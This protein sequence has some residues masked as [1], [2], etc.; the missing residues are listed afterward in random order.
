MGITSINSNYNSKVIPKS[1]T[2]GSSFVL[3]QDEDQI[4][5][6]ESSSECC[7]GIVDIVNSTKIAATLPCSK[8]G[9][10]Y[11]IFLNAMIVTV[12]RF[13]GIVVKNGG[14]S[15][16]YYFQE[17]TTDQKSVFLRCLECSLA[18]TEI[19]Q[20]INAKLQEEKIPPL[21][22]R[23]S[24]DYGKV[25][26]AKSCNSSYHDIFGTPVNICSKINCRALPN[27]VVVGSDLYHAAKNSPGYRFHEVQGY[28]VGFKFQYPVYRATRDDQQ[29][30]TVIDTAIKR[31]L[32]EMGTPVLDVITT[33][34]FTE[35]GC[36]L[37]DCYKHPENLKKILMDI[38]GNSHISIMETIRKNL[39]SDVQQKPI[40]EFLEKL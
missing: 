25:T 38:F 39:D 30:E 22:Y 4:S 5:F 6:I 12:K 26:L 16:L 15:L 36:L 1:E 34:L 21:N 37:S 9:K 23:V 13:G 17:D 31:A 35:Y 19:H 8:I 14:D 10:Y 18:M 24:A 2:Q 7:V 3:N 27:T 29:C 33:R 20:K 32:L 40:V 11:G 28:S